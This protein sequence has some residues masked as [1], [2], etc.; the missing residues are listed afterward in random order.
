M[1]TTKI[2][3]I[4]LVTTKIFGRDQFFC[5]NFGRD[6]KLVE[7]NEKGYCLT[8]SGSMFHINKM[9]VVSDMYWVVV[10]GGRVKS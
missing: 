9:L 6:Q 1:V 2:K 4:K 3:A 7:E 5:L 8:R 10:I